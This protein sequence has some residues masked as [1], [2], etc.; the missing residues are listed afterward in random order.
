M[1]LLNERLHHFYVLSHSLDIRFRRSIIDQPGSRTPPL[2]RPTAPD[3]LLALFPQ[4][5]V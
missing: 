3:F 2:K 4:H 5:D 1:R